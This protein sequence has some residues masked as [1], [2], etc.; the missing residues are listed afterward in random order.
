[1]EKA[2]HQRLVRDGIQRNKRAF[3]HV[4]RQLGSGVPTFLRARNTNLRNEKQAKIMLNNLRLHLGFP[5]LRG[6]QWDVDIV[7]RN[8][9]VDFSSCAKQVGRVRLCAT[10]GSSCK[11]Q[12]E[13]GGR[14]S[15]EDPVEFTPRTR[16][17]AK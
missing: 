12:D 3:R 2:H 1:M 16:H 7:F 13:I 10:K 11:T 8:I 15:A 4:D 17:W 14:S 5:N 9:T 6:R